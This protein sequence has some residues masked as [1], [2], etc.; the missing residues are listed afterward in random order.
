MHLLCDLTFIDEDAD[1]RECHRVFPLGT[2]VTEAREGDVRWAEEIAICED[3]VRY[4]ARRGDRDFY[5]MMLGGRPRLLHRRY[6]DPEFEREKHRGT[7]E[8][9][10]GADLVRTNEDRPHRDRNE[11]DD[12]VRSGSEINRTE[13]LL[14]TSGHSTREDF[15]FDTVQQPRDADVTEAEQE[16]IGSSIYSGVACEEY[17]VSEGPGGGLEYGLVVIVDFLNVLVKAF[18]AG[19]PSKIHAVQSMLRT[20][21]NIVERLSPEYL[22]FALDGGH[23]Q[24]S[25]E[26]PDYKAHRPPKPPELVEQIILAERAIA[27]IG[28]PMVRVRKWEADDVIASLAAKIAPHAGG[29]IVCSCDKDLLQ[30][31]G[32]NGL[33]IYHPWDGGTYLGAKHVEDKYSVKKSQFVDYLS[34]VGDASDGVPGVRGIGPKKAAELLGIY[35][36]LGAILEAARC[37]LIPGA[38]GK[39]LREQADAARM[40]RRLVELCRDLVIPTHWHDRPATSPSA[41]WVDALRSMD[42]GAVARRLAEVLPIT[43]R[44]RGG[45][46]LIEVHDERAT[47]SRSAVS[48]GS[49]VPA[50]VPAKHLDS[51]RRPDGADLSED[52]A[53]QGP[54]ATGAC[55]VRD[56]PLVGEVQPAAVDVSSGT[57]PLDGP[58]W[59]IRFPVLAKLPPGSNWVDSCRSTYADAYRSFLKGEPRDE[60]HWKPESDLWFAFHLGI[61]GRPFAMPDRITLR[62]DPPEQVLKPV[63][64][65]REA[66]TAGLDRPRSP[67]VPEHSETMQAPLSA[68]SARQTISRGQPVLF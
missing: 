51:E 15:P 53:H 10:G 7:S 34:L 9:A 41:G 46:S 44:V 56:Q 66:G 61:N 48:S 29:V 25:A 16:Q 27:A 18:H 32:E 42:L 3:R 62:L 57:V 55:D 14:A 65:S 31:A 49:G 37:L 5:V 8:S 67:A 13:R 54:N 30:L 39:A 45:S 38:S 17:G 12:S 24:R 52:T 36:D 47:T 22:I 26:F 68:A 64:I 6:W 58:D 19:A 20:C 60:S 1:G 43:G 4:Y 35:P 33:K 2:P 50:E 23:A 11:T 21:A 40:S 59:F 63:S 28:W